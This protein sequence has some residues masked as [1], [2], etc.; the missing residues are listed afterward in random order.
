MILSWF[1]CLKTHI[2]LTESKIRRILLLLQQLVQQS[3]TGP[4]YS[5]NVT[6]L[7]AELRIFPKMFR[8]TCLNIIYVIHN[9]C[10]FFGKNEYNVQF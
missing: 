4:L 2:L 5:S 6:P 10:R 1:Q 9:V 7:E 3:T 8:E